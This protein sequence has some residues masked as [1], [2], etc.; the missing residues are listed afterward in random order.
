MIHQRTRQKNIHVPFSKND[1]K[2]EFLISLNYK[3]CC[4]HMQHECLE[5]HGEFSLTWRAQIKADWKC[6]MQAFLCLY[7]LLRSLVTPNKINSLIK[8]SNFFPDYSKNR[9]KVKNTSLKKKKYFTKSNQ[10]CKAVILQLIINI[11]KS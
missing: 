11:L 5:P 4:Y 6:S 8:L 7:Y 1:W 3:L 2:L 9:D 10:L